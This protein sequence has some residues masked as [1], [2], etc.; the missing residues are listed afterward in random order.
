M[1][2]S[3]AAVSL[4]GSVVA[5]HLAVAHDGRGVAHALHLFEAMRD[6][7]DRLSLGAQPFQR[8]EQ[9]VGFLRRQ[10]RSGLV[11]DDEFRLLQ[12]AA[13]DLDA[14]A[15]ADR[16]VADQRIGVERQPVAVGERLGL[17][18]D[19]GNRRL[20]VERQRDVFRGR[21]RL[22][23]REVLEH[24]ADAKLLGR[25]RAADPDRRAVPAYFAGIGLKRAEQHLHQR[26]L[27]GAVFAEQRVDLA[28]ADRQVDVVA[29]L[30]RAEDFRQAA[31]LQQ[32]R[33][34]TVSTHGASHSVF[35]M[36]SMFPGVS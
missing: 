33:T 20:V 11:E 36:C 16:Q 4:R 21:Q 32:V 15:L 7:E 23:Q 5:D 8:L 26:R 2:A 19:G 3:D 14:L 17:C 27:A 25:T 34:I 22:E 24:H 31:N 10:N 29:S 30:Q 18:G 9:L 1:R 12:Q 6:V 13:D 35:Q 28:L